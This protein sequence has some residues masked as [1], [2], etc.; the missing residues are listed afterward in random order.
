MATSQDPY[1]D[2]P[3][4]Q[5]ALRAFAATHGLT[6][7]GPRIIDE[8][9]ATGRSATAGGR[10][11]EVLRSVRFHQK[12]VCLRV[13]AG[14]LGDWARPPLADADRQIG[15]MTID[16]TAP[17]D[18]PNRLLG[19]YPQAQQDLWSFG[20]G[21]ILVWVRP[22]AVVGHVA[23]PTVSVD[24]M[25]RLLA[26][27]V[28]VAQVVEQQNPH[29]VATVRPTVRY[30]LLIAAAVLGGIGLLLLLFVVGIVLL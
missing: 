4:V 2:V 26:A 7:T 30:D 28:N 14:P 23:T 19:A 9:F 27:L 8:V 20:E 10:H 12:A 29:Y 22:D 16:V 1:P 24:S 6:Y 25:H 21:N 3:Q 15:G 5:D 17:G 13:S 18:G 11:V